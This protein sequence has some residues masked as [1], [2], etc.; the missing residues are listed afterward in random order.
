M[1]VAAFVAGMVLSFALAWQGL[2]GP[3]LKFSASHTLTGTTARLIGGLCALFGLALAA[4]VLW[5]ILQMM[6]DRR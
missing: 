1:L 4:G 2:V 6:G 5:A 3:G